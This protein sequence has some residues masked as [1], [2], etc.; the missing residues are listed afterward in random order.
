MSIGHIPFAQIVDLVE[1]RLSGAALAQVQAHTAACSDCAAELAWVAHVIVLMRDDNAD[2]APVQVVNRAVDLFRMRRAP[3]LSGVR[4][5][6]SAELRFDSWRTLQ[7]LG[8]RGSARTERQLLFSVEGFDVDVRI[9]HSG[10]AW[11]V[12]GQVLG[13]D[14]AGVVALT[15]A[16]NM[17]QGVLNELSEFK[18]SV[19]SP[20]AYTL[21]VDLP[22][23]EIEIAGLEVGV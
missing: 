2:D 10:E 11:T 22:S 14:R 13:P 23:V 7:R 18:F 1:G 12:A 5:R 3:D 9:T 4:Q 16:G 6:L 15:S 21:V 8:L 19:V 17:V 20:G